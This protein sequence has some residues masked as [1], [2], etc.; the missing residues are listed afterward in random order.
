MLLAIDIG[1]TRTTFALMRGTS[2]IAEEHASSPRLNFRK[3]R[4]I[5]R[6]ISV[7][8]PGET[9]SS[10]G[11]ASV[12]PTLTDLV[13]NAADE[14]VRKPSQLVTSQSARFETSY[15]APDT[16]GADRIC[17]AVAAF[18]HAKGAAIVIDCGTAITL[19]CIGPSGEFLGGAI[20]PGYRTAAQS[21]NTTTAQLPEV[22]LN[23]PALAMGQSTDQ[24]L[25]S[26]IVLGTTYAIEGLIGRMMF[27]SF[28]NIFPELI[29]TGGHADVFLKTSSLRANKLPDL[30]LTGIA[31]IFKEERILIET[32]EK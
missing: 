32:S 12:V 15:T 8:V 5:I 10:T 9:I 1:N 2:V 14:I 28:D 23:A 16:I 24:C 6:T 7:A 13:R 27:E 26:G 30:V 31:L 4:E 22:I 19:D 17:N 11:I 3:A 18:H 21:L 29:V 25:R 20:L